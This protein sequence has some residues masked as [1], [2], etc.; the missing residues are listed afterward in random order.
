M[1][2]ESNFIHLVW[3]VSEPRRGNGMVVWQERDEQSDKSRKS[4]V[5]AFN[6]CC[7]M[8]YCQPNYQETWRNY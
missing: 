7:V 4:E 1:L 8:H 5:K 2:K 6:V 3:W